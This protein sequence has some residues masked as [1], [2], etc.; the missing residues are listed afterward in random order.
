MEAPQRTATI[1]DLI[2]SL[3]TGSFGERAA[4]STTLKR[5]GAPAVEPLLLALRDPSPLAADARPLVI[6]T[7]GMVGDARALAPLLEELRSPRAD[8]RQAAARALRLLGN[9]VAIPALIDLF[10][11]DERATGDEAGVVGVWEEAATAVASFGEPALAPLCAA[12]R[13]ASANVRAWSIVALG[14][15]GDTRAVGLLAR[16]LVDPAPS[17]RAHAADALASLGDTA[18]L[19][20][21][22]YVL[23]QDADAF[24]RGRVAYAL[25][26]F[27]G[28]VSVDALLPA[29]RDADAGVR[30]AVAYAIGC[31]GDR[32]ATGILISL[33]SDHADQVREAA[34]LRL[35]EIGDEQ[36]AE[37]LEPLTLDQT[38]AQGVRAFAVAAVERIRSRS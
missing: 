33:L 1:N 11:Q 3:I 18:A 19:P 32:R 21:L 12:L 6:E 24:V 7:L 25:G 8:V 14:R 38:G 27:P 5:L 36:V 22:A 17:V 31:S 29:L 26:A 15:L 4:A 10:R 2:R 30:C 35:G 28:S 20:P 13:D 9:P 34:V 37:T 16:M 23:R